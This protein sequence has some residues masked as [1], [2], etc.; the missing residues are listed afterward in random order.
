MSNLSTTE[1]NSVTLEW[2]YPPKKANQPLVASCVLT[3]DPFDFRMG[4]NL[5]WLKLTHILGM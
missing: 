2:H 5:S 4:S 3:L 1:I